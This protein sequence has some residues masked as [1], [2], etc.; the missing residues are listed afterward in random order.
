MFTGVQGETRNLT[1][2]IAFYIGSGLAQLLKDRFNKPTNE[3][4]VSVRIFYIIKANDK[5]KILYICNNYLCT[6]K[7]FWSVGALIFLCLT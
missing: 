2:I 5:R 7:G 1:P 6:Q 3:L 4:K